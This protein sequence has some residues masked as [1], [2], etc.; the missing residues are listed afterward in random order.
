MADPAAVLAERFS[1]AIV[2]AFGAELAGTDPLIRRSQQPQFGDY[3]ANVAMSLAKRVGAAPREVAARIIEHL[4]VADL[5][6][7][8]EVAGPGFV[9]IRL[10][11][12][13]IVAALAEAAAD[14]RAGVLPAARPQRV[15][16]DYSSP[17][18][19]KEMHVG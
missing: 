2:A 1:S 11:P 17:N 12:D 3:Q 13:A 19:A 14:E 16:V 5:C 7:P 15:V 18:V 8:P 10:R 9:N 6:D 4:D